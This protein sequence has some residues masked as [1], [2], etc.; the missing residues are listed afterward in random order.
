[1]PPS[2]PPIF[3]PSK[4]RAKWCMTMHALDRI[5]LPYRVI[6]EDQEHD[7]Y[8][9][10]LGEDRLIVLPHSYKQE[11]DVCTDEPGGTGSGPARNVAWDTAEAEGHPWHWVMDDNIRGWWRLHRNRRIPWGDTTPFDAMEDYAS[12]WS[13]VAMLGPQY[14]M[15]A[16]SRSRAPALVTG[17]RIYSCNLIRT[18]T[19]FRWRGRYNEDTDL[20]LRMLKAGWA[21]VL[22]NAFLQWKMTTQK[23]PGG[24]TD[25]IYANGTLAKSQM[26]VRL[27]PDVAR[28]TYR[29]NRW[30]HHVDYRQWLGQPLIPDPEYTPPAENP[31]RLTERARRG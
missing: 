24:N 30:H 10:Q 1:M 9:A 5:G 18:S 17:T 21:T 25:T 14:F 3:V 7:E 15:F 28:L 23:M 4:G 8:A 6:V 11:Y 12:R 29:Y 27:H 20:S 13:N 2:R 19:P 16:P 26:I 31:Y 22:F